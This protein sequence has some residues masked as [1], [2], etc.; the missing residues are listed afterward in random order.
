MFEF[1]RLISVKRKARTMKAQSKLWF[2]NY[3]MFGFV[4]QLEA[5]C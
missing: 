4:S 2:M 3:L 5:A 1:P